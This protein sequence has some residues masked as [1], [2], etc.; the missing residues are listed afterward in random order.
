LQ[1][2]QSWSGFNGIAKITTP[3]SLFFKKQNW[4]FGNLAEFNEKSKE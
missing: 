2:F 1:G 3:K 4:Y